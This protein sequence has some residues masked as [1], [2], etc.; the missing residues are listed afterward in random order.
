MTSHP[1]EAADTFPVGNRGIEGGQLDPGVV[2]VVVDDGVAE[3]V[4]ASSLVSNNR[5]A[6]RSEDGTRGA[7]AS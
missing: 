5:A 4:R 3:V 7:S 2:G 1:L 6:S